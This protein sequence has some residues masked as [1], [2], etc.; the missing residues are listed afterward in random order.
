[1]AEAPRQLSVFEWEAAK[2]VDQAADAYGEALAR[3]RRE[4]TGE[5]RSRKARLRDAMTTL[6]RVEME[7]VRA[8]EP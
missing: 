4:V 2:A 1:V 5:I 7:L 3:A 8:R 6:L